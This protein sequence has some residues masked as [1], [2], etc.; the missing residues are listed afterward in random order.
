MLHAVCTGLTCTCLRSGGVGWAHVWVRPSAC[1]QGRHVSV[2]LC[3]GR[4]CRGVLRTFS[5]NVSFVLCVFDTVWPGGWGEGG[6]GVIVCLFHSW[7]LC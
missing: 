1:S 2:F 7:T 4:V 5:S 3:N 6:G